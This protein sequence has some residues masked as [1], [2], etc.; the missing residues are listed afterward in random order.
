V[1]Y[2]DRDVNWE[3]WIPTAGDPLPSRIVVDSKDRQTTTRLE[4]VF[5]DWNLSPTIADEQF[6]PRV[7]SDYEGIAMIQR[8]A[9]LRHIPEDGAVPAATTGAKP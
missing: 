5:R 6:V 8:A 3:M 1:K 7:P 4:V 2:S 9:V